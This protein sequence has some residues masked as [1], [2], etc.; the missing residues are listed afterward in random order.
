[1]TRTSGSR[2]PAASAIPRRA[3]RSACGPDQSA[4]DAAL[5]A[6]HHRG[7]AAESGQRQQRGGRLA[8]AAGPRQQHPLGRAV[9]QQVPD[10]GAVG[11]AGGL[12]RIPRRHV[13]DRAPVSGAR[14]GEPGRS[15]QHRQR[16]VQRRAQQF[17]RDDAVDDAV[18]VQVLRGLDARRERLAVE[19]LVDPR[20]EEADQRARLGGGDVAQR[21][22][23]REH[24]AGR[25]VP[26][27]HQVGQMRLLVQFD[28]GGDL[29]HLQEGDRALLHA[30][31]AGTRA[32]PP[33]AAASAVARS[34]AAVIRSAAATPIEPAR[35]SNSQATTAT[36]R[37]NTGAL[38]GQHRFVE[39]RWRPWRCGQFA[40]VRVVGGDV[41]W[42]RCPS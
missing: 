14:G 4:A 29:D 28:R 36:R 1:M 18:P 20:P 8:V 31:A 13:G 5:L 34:I 24:P 42:G 41:E 2:S 38:A 35:K 22:P 15:R 23:R 30:G 32:T 37:P 19:V 39:A 40:A 33:A 17:D 10:A 26:Q 16:A 27:I 6:D 21:P 3:S 25:R 11:A 12:H 7:L 9:P